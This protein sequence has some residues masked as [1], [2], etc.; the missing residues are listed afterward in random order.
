MMIRVLSLELLIWVKKILSYRLLETKTI[1]EGFSGWKRLVTV[2][3]F[4]VS[5]RIRKGIRFG[6]KK[7]REHKFLGCEQKPKNSSGIL[8][9]LHSFLMMG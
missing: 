7:G 8:G 1:V 2:K 4:R 5:N 9:L 3:N 6:C